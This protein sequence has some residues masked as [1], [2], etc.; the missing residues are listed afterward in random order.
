[1][2]PHILFLLCFWALTGTASADRPILFKRT[3]LPETPRD[4]PESCSDSVRS[5]LMNFPDVDYKCTN[6]VV[7][8][9]CGPKLRTPAYRFVEA[10]YQLFGYTRGDLYRY[11][12][13]SL[14][15]QYHGVP[16]LGGGGIG[17]HAAKRKDGTTVL[18]I[19][20]SKADISSLNIDVRPAISSATAIAIA[21]K[22]W[23]QS[24]DK[25]LID[26]ETA[27]LVINYYPRPHLSW[28]VLGT[29]KFENDLVRI[30]CD[31]N[32]ERAFPITTND[33]S[34]DLSMLRSR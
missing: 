1:M 8:T 25:N 29:R 24:A 32:A 28:L 20:V 4:P 5:L 26:A 14:T 16:L 30:A 22:S 9:I 6:G 33:C 11:E 18:C 2:K 23:H 13:G 31:V 10:N 27:R 3:P 34:S 12:D 15:Q 17:G 19:D 7:S 21:L